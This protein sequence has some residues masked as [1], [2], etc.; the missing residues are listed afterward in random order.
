MEIVWDERKRLANID[1]HGIDFADIPLEFFES[2]L[3][4]RAKD[5]RWFALGLLDAAIVSARPA[6]RKER[7]AIE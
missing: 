2:A 5:G 4:G 1:K 3:I 7:K 6:S